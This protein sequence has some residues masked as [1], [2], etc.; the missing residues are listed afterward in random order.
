[1]EK[2]N[3]EIHNFYS[4]KY[5]IRSFNSRKMR[6]HV[7]RM[8]SREIS[9]SENLKGQERLRDLGIDGNSKNIFQRNEI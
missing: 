7:E 4:L 3:D 1:M 8:G 9:Y 5:I 2:Q 6:R